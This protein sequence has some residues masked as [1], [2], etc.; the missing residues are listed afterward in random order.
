MQMELK[1]KKLE[2]EMQEE[3]NDTVETENF[4]VE[5]IIAEIQ[6]TSKRYSAYLF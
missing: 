6:E 2:V 4:K 3:L 5:E 1:L